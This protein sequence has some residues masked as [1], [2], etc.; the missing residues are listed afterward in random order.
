MNL[1]ITINS[2]TVFHIS[3]NKYDN[4]SIHNT[5]TFKPQSSINHML[6]I[7]SFVVTEQVITIDNTASIVLGHITV[8]ASVNV[9]QQFHNYIE[10]I[11]K[12]LPSSIK[13]QLLFVP[14]NTIVKQQQLQSSLVDKNLNSQI[15]ERILPL[16]FVDNEI[17]PSGFIFIG[18]GTHQSIGIGMHVYSHFIPTV[19]RQELNLQDPYIAKWNKELLSTVGQIA[20]CFY[21]QTINHSSHNRSDNYYNALII[22]TTCT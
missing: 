6:H 7:D 10:R 21:D 3:K 17:I 5:F 9:D 14:F 12:R 22:L 2:L 8:E 15:L 18:L 11:L 19:E 16:K 1:V 4:P 13:I 20:R